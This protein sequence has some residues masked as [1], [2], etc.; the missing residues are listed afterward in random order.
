LFEGFI[1]FLSALQYYN[2][3]RPNCQTIVLNSLINIKDINLDQYEK[4]NLF[5]DNDPPGEQATAEIKDRY[6]R[7]KDYSHLIY[8][9]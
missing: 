9:I 1:D 8:G 6:N 7:V 3:T 4:I 2:V 5:L